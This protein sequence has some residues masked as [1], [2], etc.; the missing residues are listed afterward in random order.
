M[1]SLFTKP[2]DAL[3]AQDAAGVLGW[4]ESLNIEFKRTL[5]G[6]NGRLDA[7]INGG[8]FESYA[9]DKLFKEVVAFANT[10][11]G[12]L[13]LGVAET[14]GAP[15]PHVATALTPV[16]RCEEL[17]ERL[18]RAAQTIDPPIPLLLVR[19]IPIHDGA[20][21]VVFRVP[22][23]RNA[24]HRSTD[25]ECY[26]RRGTDSVP[27]NMREIQD[28]TLATG[29]REDLTDARF[30]QAAKQFAEWFATP[31]EDELQ[32]VG[33]R[34][35]AVPVGARFDLGRLHGRDSLVQLQRQY[36][37]TLKGHRYET[38]A[39]L[40]PDRTRAIVRGVR[41]TDN[42]EGANVYLDL[43]SNGVVDLGFKVPPRRDGQIVALG[44][45]I[46]YAVNVLS[47]V[48][49]L[50]TEAAAPD[51]EY[52]IQV[53]LCSRADVDFVELNG[54]G[55]PDLW[56]NRIGDGLRRLPLLLPRLSFGPIG[57]LDQVVSLMVNDLCD[58]SAAYNPEAWSLSIDLSPYR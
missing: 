40:W 51:C 6:R 50:R 8:D 31:L 48:N 9:R 22:A 54:L 57:E 23:S 45:I 11:G 56:R 10:S 14:E 17:A 43:Y 1:I 21:V 3:D 36:T 46:A 41:R 4:P 13:V 58:A 26:A 47:A 18:A 52:G 29:R 42:G 39:P 16:P 19:G 7:W 27:M 34:I 24:P 33:L 28:M 32:A 53:E 30:T 25:K 2:I 20:G 5:P 55:Q 15:P 49:M 44:W 35:T 12:H 37:I 38:Y